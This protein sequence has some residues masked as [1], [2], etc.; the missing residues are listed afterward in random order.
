M[1]RL[2]ASGLVSCVS[3]K[4]LRGRAIG[5]ADTMVDR[6]VRAIMDMDMLKST[7]VRAR[8]MRALWRQAGGC[9]SR[10]EGNEWMTISERKEQ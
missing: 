4:P 8:K 3:E 5:T 7:M 2:W 9:K 1:V 10:S 6:Q